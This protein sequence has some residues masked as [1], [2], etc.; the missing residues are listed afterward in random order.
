MRTPR[1]LSTVLDILPSFRIGF[2]T[3]YNMEN[4]QEDLI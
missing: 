1:A 2:T 3:W 4:V